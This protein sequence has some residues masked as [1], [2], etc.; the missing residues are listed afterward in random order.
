MNQFRNRC[1]NTLC[2]CTCLLLKIWQEKITVMNRTPSYLWSNGVKKESSTYINKYKCTYTHMHRGTHKDTTV[3]DLSLPL[4]CEYMSEW[5]II[6]FA[7]VLFCFVFLV[8]LH[9]ILLT[10][11]DML[12]VFFP[13]F[14]DKRHVKKQQVKTMTHWVSFAGVVN[15]LRTSVV[16]PAM[17]G[18]IFKPLHLITIGMVFLQQL[19]SRNG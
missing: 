19:S 6:G 3:W 16:S 12:W 13:W 10:N 11:K 5:I 2:Y 4:T 8:S 17:Q 18:W 14:S 15:W 1:M 7:V 9:Y